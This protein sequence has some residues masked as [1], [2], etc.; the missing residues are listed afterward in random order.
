MMTPAPSALRPFALC[1]LSLPGAAQAT[2]PLTSVDGRICLL[3]GAATSGVL[4]FFCSDEEAMNASSNTV[5]SS[6]SATLAVP[7]DGTASLSSQ[8]TASFRGGTAEAMLLFNAR[9]ALR[10]LWVAADAELARAM[11]DGRPVDALGAAVDK[12][13]PM[14]GARDSR[15]AVT[16]AS[17]S[18]PSKRTTKGG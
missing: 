8:A 16:S 17:A 9:D 14:F 18:G 2:S 7:D 11:V 6:G 3:T 5:P 10:D 1:L 13:R 12:L 4:P 15:R